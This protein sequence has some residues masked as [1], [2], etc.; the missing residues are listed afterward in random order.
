MDLA[1]VAT[2]LRLVLRVA[3]VVVVGSAVLVDLWIIGGRRVL[4]PDSVRLS[5]LAIGAIAIL[6]AAWAV[7]PRHVLLV[8]TAA[9]VISL[10]ETS[11]APAPAGRGS[12]SSP[13]SS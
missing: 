8:A 11:A 2:P 4:D 12:G 6:G 9:S 5:A 13:S 10:L 7:K 1:R 3:F